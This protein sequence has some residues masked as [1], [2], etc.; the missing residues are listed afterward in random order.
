MQ[1]LFPEAQVEVNLEG[2]IPNEEAL[3]VRA[4]EPLLIMAFNNLLKNAIQ[5]SEAQTAQIIIRFKPT[6]KEIGFRNNGKLFLPEE[7]DLIF[8]PFSGRPPLLM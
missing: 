3:L 2:D 6:G 1:N 4:N 8:A 7:R 5:Y